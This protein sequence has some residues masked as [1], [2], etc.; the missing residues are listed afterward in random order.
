MPMSSPRHLLT[1]IAAILCLAV[2]SR[3]DEPVTVFTAEQINFFEQQVRPVLAEHCFECHGAKKQESGLRLD[4]RA[5]VLKGGDSGD[6]VKLGA[7]EESSLVA[8][9]RRGGELKMPPDKTLP[10]TAVAALTKWVELW[11]PWPSSEPNATGAAE[12]WRKHWAFQ[13]VRAPAIPATKAIE[14][15]RSA[16]DAFVLAKLEASG[17]GPSPVA[18]R[19]TLIRRLS[20]AWLGLPPSPDEVADFA[21]DDAPD[22]VARLADRLLASPRYG[23]RWG[24]HWLDVAR[25]ADN[26]GY[27]FFEEKTFPW[28]Y[29][30]RDYVVE[31][32][33]RDLPFDRFVTEQLAADQLDLGDDARPL[34]ALGF[35]TVGAHFMNNTHDIL[36][37]RIDVVTRGLLGLTVG[38]AR[39]H[40]HKYD[41]IPQADYYSL[42]GVFRSS[43][44][45]TVLPLFAPPA[46]TDEYQKFVAE[47]TVREGKLN[48][49]VTRKH[50]EL[51][52][53]ARTRAAEYLLA[54]HAQRNHPAT[55][56]FMLL[57]DPGELNPTMI[58]RW[59]VYLEKATKRRH[60]AWVAWQRFAA[61]DDVMFSQL[62]PAVV[63]E[64]A[65]LP[66]GDDAAKHSN[67]L[68]KQAFVA[69]PPQSMNDVATTYGELLGGVN[70]Q[71]L[72]AVAHAAQANQPPPTN[73]PDA[74]DE[75]LRRVFYGPD[76]PPD[77]PLLIGWGFLTLLPDRAAQ[78]EYQK[79]IKE[80][81][82]W[83]MTGPGA[84][85]RA[86]V[87]AD[88]PQPHEPRIFQRGNPNR[89]GDPVPR[90]FLA[91][92]NPQRQ[93]FRLGSGRLELAREIVRPENPLTSRVLVNRVW[94]QL[95]GQGLVRTPGDFGL[96][97][98]PPSHPELLDHMAARFVA[99]GWS[100]KR[101]QRELVLTATYQQ[102][103][104]DRA[105]AARI[106][107]ENRLVWKM[108][109][110]RLDFEA[111]RDSL[112]S[113]AGQ[114]DARLGGPP[115]QLLGDG[116][117]PRRTLYGFIDR[118]DVAPLLTTFDFPN[119]AQLSPQ[120]DA[121]TV[122]PQALYLMNNPLIAAV[123]D[124]ALRRP[125]VARLTETDERLRH[126]H[127][128]CFARDPSAD[129]LR[130]AHEF[131]GPQPPPAR[132]L[133]YVQ[134]LLLTNEFAFVD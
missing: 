108:N 34:R 85:P 3:A 40:D 118:L 10:A 61:L 33:N 96:R 97:S 71:W 18:D 103:S 95:L 90:Q 88:S 81:E 24:R 106:D 133:A 29:T 127:A 69:K 89:L 1:M 129:D 28:A 19:R 23:E 109:A 17:L 134:A 100:I 41:P 26:K 107:S 54:A 77:V 70:K 76:A 87:L 5:A 2:S 124:N 113:V 62:A 45:P 9:I 12:A 112:L 78:G 20:F 22:A 56:D 125:D 119:P 67:R 86:M 126:L 46:A 91:V 84:P 116:I 7:P 14:W 11:L 59:R 25:Y 120:R 8:A 51:V 63:Q 30:Y 114:L 38:C 43:E 102:A 98:D 73:L 110:R 94:L 65:A 4:S 44:E 39:C 6:V 75:E 92:A 74:A 64:L 57:A 27:V 115:V 82:Q 15:P 58:L 55:D 60:P 121:T 48:E 52:T 66:D 101:L 132:W 72:D 42:Y 122:A 53:G 50:T 117:V 93:P 16:I 80:T 131:L 21:T 105:H 13:P 31:A 83:L 99:D 128:L 79:L 36:D 123:A 35:L 49:F 68:V 104:V 111:L 47:L 37:D 32:F 130:L